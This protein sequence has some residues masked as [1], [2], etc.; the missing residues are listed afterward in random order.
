MA[1]EQPVKHA[2]IEIPPD[3]PI[4]VPAGTLMRVSK[5]LDFCLDVGSL[6]PI[7]PETRALAAEF[8]AAVARA[9][10]A[11]IKGAGA[12]SARPSKRR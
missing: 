12:R 11:A 3:Y 5:F 8:E 7:H 10:H 9:A 6:A 2:S 1:A 4:P